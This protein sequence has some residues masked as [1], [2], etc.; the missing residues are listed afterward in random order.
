MRLLEVVRDTHAESSGQRLP[1][2]GAGAAGAAL[3]DMGVPPTS[4]RGFVLIA[5]TAGLVAHLAEEVEHPLGMR[6]WQEVEDRARVA[7]TEETT[8]GH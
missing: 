3:A 6:L 8:P 5:R 7:D 4:V 1:I 2:N